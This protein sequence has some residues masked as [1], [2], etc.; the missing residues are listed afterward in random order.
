MLL[1]NTVSISCEGYLTSYRSISAFC[2]TSEENIVTCEGGEKNRGKEEEEED[3]G[4]EE[5]Q[6]KKKKEADV[7]IFMGNGLL[8]TGEKDNCLE[9]SFPVPAQFQTLHLSEWIWVYVCMCYKWF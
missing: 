3:G 5:E 8:D 9:Y 4:R 2:P 6:K 7:N 1:V